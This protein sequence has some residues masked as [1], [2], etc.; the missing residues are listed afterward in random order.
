MVLLGILI[1]ILLE[2]LIKEDILL[3]MCLLLEVMFSVGKLLCRHHLCCRLPRHNIWLLQK[4]V[5]KLFG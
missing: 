1:L 3:G 5:R 4:L 2:I